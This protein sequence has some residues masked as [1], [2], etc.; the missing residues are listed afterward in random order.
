MRNM[1][2]TCRSHCTR[3]HWSGI[4]VHMERNRCQD[5][6]HAGSVPETYQSIA[7]EQALVYQLAARPAAM[8]ATALCR[9]QTMHSPVQSAPAALSRTTSMEAV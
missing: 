4:T 9:G 2:M 8:G 5:I 6:A 1:N 7:F 3:S